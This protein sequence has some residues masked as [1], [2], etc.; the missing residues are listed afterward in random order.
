MLPR[1]QAIYLASRTASW[2]R[3]STEQMSVVVQD[4]PSL[5]L[6]QRMYEIAKS[7]MLVDPVA[8]FHKKNFAQA[9][10]HV[11]HRA[12]SELSLL[13]PYC[14]APADVGR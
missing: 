2:M 11:E 9:W 13:Q 3:Q 5:L 1:F 7:T 4:V 6:D 14:A 12:P 10:R 8:K